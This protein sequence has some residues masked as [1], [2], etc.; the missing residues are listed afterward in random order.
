MEYIDNLS[1]YSTILIMFLLLAMIPYIF[2]KM[3]KKYMLNLMRAILAKCKDINSCTLFGL[4]CRRLKIHL[5]L[6]FNNLGLYKNSDF[7]YF[8]I[9]NTL[10]KEHIL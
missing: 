7:N 8:H 9:S 10:I 1:N 5:F 3:R 2:G 6:N 4:I